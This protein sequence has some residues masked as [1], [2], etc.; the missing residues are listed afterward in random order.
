MSRPQFKTFSYPQM[1]SADSLRNFVDYRV[2]ED[3]PIA[4][5]A[6]VASDSKLDKLVADAVDKRAKEIARDDT[7]IE[8]IKSDLMT[9]QETLFFG[10]IAIGGIIAT[11][12]CLFLKR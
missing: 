12:V 9:H 2:A 1:I 7:I 6:Y 3:I 8:G 5:S 10:G 4:M 11:A